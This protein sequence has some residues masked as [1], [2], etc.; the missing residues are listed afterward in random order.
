MGLVDITKAIKV[1]LDSADPSKD[2]NSLLNELGV[3]E[4]DF[5]EFVAQMTFA[6]VMS[7]LGAVDNDPIAVT[8]GALQIAL[9][10]G[11]RLRVSQESEG[12]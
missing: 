9:Q 6:V 3:S 4:E 8:R 1:E 12:G 10:V 5:R 11:Y 2:A 7:A